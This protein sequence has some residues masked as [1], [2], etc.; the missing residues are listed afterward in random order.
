MSERNIPLVGRRTS[1]CLR[2]RL[3]FDG[4]APRFPKCSHPPRYVPDSERT[5]RT[6]R[7][8]ASHGPSN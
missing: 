7:S 5:T 3:L 4:N 8:F 1:Q 2:K 6:L